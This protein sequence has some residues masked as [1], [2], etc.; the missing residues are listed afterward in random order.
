M[1]VYKA[2]DIAVEKLGEEQV[3]QIE[4]EAR[5]ELAREH[6][7]ANLRAV[8]EMA[9]KTQVDLARA[10]GISQAEL[11]RNESAGD[12]LVST[13]R[14]YVEALGGELEVLARFGDKTVKLRG[15]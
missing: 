4:R 5:A 8:R 9:G 10:A 2:R 14:R 13:L 1:K 3:R 12:H 11:S 15:V 7:E 6:L